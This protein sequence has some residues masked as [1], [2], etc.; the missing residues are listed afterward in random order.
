MANSDISRNKAFQSVGMSRTE[1]IFELV[2][3]DID[4][5]MTHG[6]LDT[7]PPAQAFLKK[8]R[9]PYFC[10]GHVHEDYGTHRMNQDYEKHKKHYCCM[11]LASDGGNIVGSTS[12]R[13]RNTDLHERNS[14]NDW[15]KRVLFD[16]FGQRVRMLLQINCIF[17]NLVNCVCWLSMTL[18]GN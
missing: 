1:H 7:L 5:L 17:C 11:L 8:N 15:H 2:P 10:C 14:R 18:S 12:R 9:T 4:I 3:P 16:M 6:P 13:L